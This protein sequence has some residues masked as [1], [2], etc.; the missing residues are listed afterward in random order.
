MPGRFV[1]TVWL[2]RCCAKRTG[3]QCECGGRRQRRAIGVSGRI[4]R[5]QELALG[6]RD[7]GDGPDAAA[8]RRESRV[9][10]RLGGQGEGLGGAVGG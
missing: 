8:L 4:F 1:H 7:I 3:G 5:L 10:R 6:E 2:F 9:E